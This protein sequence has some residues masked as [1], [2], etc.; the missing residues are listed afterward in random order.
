MT[1]EKPKTLRL[2]MKLRKSSLL[3]FFFVNC[4]LRESPQHDAMN[5]PLNSDHT[6]LIVA[7]K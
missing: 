5:S 7:E 2:P 4:T 3:F 1:T 6:F